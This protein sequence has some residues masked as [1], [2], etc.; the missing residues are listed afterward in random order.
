M[1]PGYS[2]WTPHRL[3]PH[4]GRCGARNTL[5]RIRVHGKWRNGVIYRCCVPYTDPKTRQEYW[6]L[7]E[8]A[9]RWGVHPSTVIRRDVRDGTLRVSRV[10]GRSK[11]VSRAELERYERLICKALSRQVR[12][13]MATLKRLGCRDCPG[14]I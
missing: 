8:I 1:R 14:C 5:H 11:L 7:T 4:H 6:T 12:Q 9:E 10:R 3:L 2:Q 13:H